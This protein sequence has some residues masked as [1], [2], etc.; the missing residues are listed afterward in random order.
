MRGMV[1]G[2]NASD[3]G[4]VHTEN[5]IKRK[6]EGGRI[7][8]ITEPEDKMYRISFFKRRELAE[9]T[10]VSFCYINERWGLVTPVMS[11]DL[12][13][14]HP[15]SYIISGP[16]GSGKSPL[17]IKL[18]QNLESQSTEPDFAGIILWWYGEKNAKLSP[19]SVSGKRIQYYEGVPEDFKNE[20]G[21]PALIILDDPLTEVYSKQVCTL[22]TKGCH[23]R[24]IIVLLITQNLFHQGTYCRDISLN[25]KYLVLLK[26][27][28]DEQQFS[29][30]ARQVYHENS[31]SPYES[32]LEARGKVRCSFVLYFA[33]DTDDKSRYRTRIFPDEH[34]IT[35]YVPPIGGKVMKQSTCIFYACLSRRARSW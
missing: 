18:L 13:L 21:K 11:H 20:G 5:K 12:R 3:R 33:Q 8:I 23:H 16:S 31:K 9:N 22:F 25:K 15:F 35:F 17:C 24:N 29:H 10:S 2:G 32:Y 14:K 1:L 30:L 19:Q 28:R 26:N 6:R 27:T 4:T 34:P 7:H